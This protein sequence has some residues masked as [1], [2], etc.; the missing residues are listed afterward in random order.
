MT[1]TINWRD[2]FDALDEI[3]YSGNYNMEMVLQCFGKGFAVETAEFA[4]KL[5][6][7][8]LRERY[9]DNA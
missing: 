7:Y 2:V 3:G 5:M 4:V 1:G 6:R 8:L 9:G